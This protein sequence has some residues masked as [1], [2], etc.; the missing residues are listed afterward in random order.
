MH[1][2][3]G[4]RVVLSVF[5]LLLTNAGQVPRQ[6]VASK[7]RQARAEGSG[8]PKSV[9]LGREASGN[10]F[11]A[12]SIEIGG[13]SQEHLGPIPCQSAAD[14]V[15]EAERLFRTRAGDRAKAILERAITLDPANVSAYRD[16]A[17]VYMKYHDPGSFFVTLG[18]GPA[19]E[20]FSRA[21]V[22]CRIAL[23][24]APDD[25]DSLL[26]LGKIINHKTEAIG[27]GPDESAIAPLSR[28][29]ELRPDL[30][31]LYSE[32][33]RAY[34][35]LKQYDEA[36]VAYAR[37]E[38]LRRDKEPPDPGLSSSW[39]QSVIGDAITLSELGAK[40]G[41]YRM[42][43]QPLKDAAKLV[44][45]DEGYYEPIHLGLGKAYLA[46]GDIESATKEQDFLTRACAYKNKFV[47][48]RCR[49][50]ARELG[51]AIE[52]HR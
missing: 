34:K 14:C 15:S 36:I 1:T 27:F 9:A 43:L 11:S 16:L 48:L 6:E 45:P 13:A 52:Q 24:L 4:S 18:G 26:L 37:A 49:L 33:G 46:S 5:L 41:K 31:D 3:A 35:L 40:A 10:I 42:A 12:P 32:L 23:A 28:A 8:P 22:A 21:E 50:A 38:A 7:P 30:P 17:I 39:R 29:I 44:A 2:L 20:D 19:E 25:S 47:V 51:A